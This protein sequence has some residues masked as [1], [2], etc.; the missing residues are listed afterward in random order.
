MF[1]IAITAH[2]LLVSDALLSELAAVLNYPKL[3]KYV[4]RAIRD[5]IQER[6]A[7]IAERVV[8]TI[9]VVAS[10]DP[11]DDKL[12]ELALAGGADC[13]VSGDD[14]LLV[15]HPF[16]GLKILTPRQFLDSIDR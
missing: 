6:V 3:A 16:R 1:E 15:L 4:Q 5:G 10:R 12:L 14:D 9:R 8:P 2:T 13:L 11:G 7:Q